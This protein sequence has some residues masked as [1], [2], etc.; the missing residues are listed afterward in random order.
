MGGVANLVIS[1]QGRSVFLAGATGAIGKRLI[2]LLID[3][4][5]AVAGTTRSE[6]KAAQLE[7]AGVRPIVLDIYDAPAVLR[8]LLAVAPEVVINQL[9]DLP[10]RLDP[11]HMG[12]ALARN[13]RIRTEGALNLVTAARTAGV[14]RVIAQSVAWVYAP[15]RQPHVEDDAL[16]LNAEGTVRTTVH[17]V[18]EL[19]R[20]TL[21]SAPLAGT[22]LRY[23]R[24]YGPGTG[25]NTPRGPPGLHVDAAAYAALLALE[26]AEA[27][28]FNIAEDDA[29]VSNA[30]AH[31]ELGWDP[32]FRL[33]AH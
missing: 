1:M 25:R 10:Q 32:D 12:E 8:A 21:D 29:M 33:S 28:T 19:E 30:K 23:G 18:V 6:A 27:G 9:T 4:G 7:A 16:D 24:L 26:R 20:L 31:R 2:P 13:A 15:G 14:R 3:A 17:G 22:V 5:Y 11:A